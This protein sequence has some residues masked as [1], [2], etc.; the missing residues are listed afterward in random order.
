LRATEIISWAHRVMKNFIC[1]ARSK[2]IKKMP[3]L[4][5]GIFI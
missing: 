5:P 2:L 1:Q 3:G 4:V